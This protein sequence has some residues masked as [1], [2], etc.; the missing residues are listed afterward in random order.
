MGIYIMVVEI[1]RSERG[2]TS[3]NERMI[4]QTLLSQDEN[5]E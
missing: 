2:S 3:A 5:A 1:D 4:K